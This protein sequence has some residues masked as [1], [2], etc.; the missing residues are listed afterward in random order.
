MNPG[1]YRD[2]PEADYHKIDAYSNSRGSKFK[3][4]PAALQYSI[5]HPGADDSDTLL[6]GRAFHSATLEPS[7]FF[8]KYIKG[9]E[10]DRR[11][12]DGKAAWAQFLKESEGK[13][14]LT[15]AQY[16]LASEMQSGVLKCEDAR[17]ALRKKTDAE[18][19]LIWIDEETGVLCKAR[20]DAYCAGPKLGLDLK[21]T[22]DASL[23]EFERSILSYGYHRQGALYLDG[24]RA[25]GLEMNEFLFIAVE[26][27]P[28]YLAACYRLREDAIQIGRQ[29]NREL[30]AR[31][32][33][34]RKT[35]VWPGYS[36][37]VQD[38]SLPEWF[39][40]KNTTPNGE[41]KF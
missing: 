2:I 16:Q 40:R 38:V 9:I 6:I 37:R 35:Q 30:L 27:E 41:I 13:V 24:A 25:C 32:A 39:L 7:V 29:E 19:T 21:S 33:E 11:T 26:K 31:Y 5:E 14:V 34:C 3:K 18:L 8:S 12:K 10:V 20:I 22:R 28:P 4:A 23:A 17:L 15:P 36:D 1:I